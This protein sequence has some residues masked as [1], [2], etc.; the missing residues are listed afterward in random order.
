MLYFFRYENRKLLDDIKSICCEIGHF[1]QTQNDFLDCF[2]EADVLKKPGTDIE[3]G[4]CTWLAAMSMELG[5][6]QHKNIM[7]EFYGKNGNNIHS[8]IIE[9]LRL[10]HVMCL[11]FLSFYIFRYRMY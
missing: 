11:I 7:K 5:T 2:S 8:I 1:Y 6:E 10:F 4:K 3:D 9:I